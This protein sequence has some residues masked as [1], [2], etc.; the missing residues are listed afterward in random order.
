MKPLTIIAAVALAAAF[1]LATGANSAPE[2]YPA[3]SASQC[4]PSQWNPCR[5]VGVP[6]EYE[7]ALEDDGNDLVHVCH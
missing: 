1:S 3:I 5:G 7:L 6:T 2:C 4:S